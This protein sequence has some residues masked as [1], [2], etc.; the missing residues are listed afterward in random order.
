MQ[1]IASEAGFE[2][3]VRRYGPRMLAV[4]RR[5]LHTDE[6]EAQDVVQ[7]AWLAATRGLGEFRGEAELSTWLHRIVVNAAL[8]RLRAGR[9]RRATDAGE[10]G[11]SI[12]EARQ[13]SSGGWCADALLEAKRTR[14]TVREAIADLSPPHRTVILLRDIEERSTR[15]TAALLGI[16]PCAVKLRLLRARRAL[17][18]RLELLSGGAIPPRGRTARPRGAAELAAARAA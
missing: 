5:I 10:L 17:R 8:M 12:E 3:L 18:A 16:S 15:E 13:P 7:D 11:R 14:Q 4:A 9:H 1:T 2:A 6:T